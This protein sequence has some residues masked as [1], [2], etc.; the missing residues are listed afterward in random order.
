MFAFKIFRN[1]DGAGG[2]FGDT[3]LEATS[4]DQGKLAVY[5]AQR[6]TDGAVTIVV[7]NKTFGDLKSDVALDHLKT[8]KRAKVFVYSGADLKDINALPDAG[9][10]RVTKKDRRGKVKES[11]LREQV[12]PAMSIT[13]F[14]AQGR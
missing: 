11:V 2:E 3:S 6:S 9:V 7:V 8:A 12:F 10:A 5:A 4:S 13:L 14:V 1:Y